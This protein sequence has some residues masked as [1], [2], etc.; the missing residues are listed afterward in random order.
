MT[1]LFLKAEFLDSIWGNMVKCVLILC[2]LRFVLHFS[3]RFRCQTFKQ[4]RVFPN[5]VFHCYKLINDLCRPCVLAE[6][7]LISPCKSVGF[8]NINIISTFQGFICWNQ[9]VLELSEMPR[10]R[11]STHRPSVRDGRRADSLLRF[12]IT[13]FCLR[14]PSIQELI[15]KFH[16]VN[17]IVLR[18]WCGWLRRESNHVKLDELAGPPANFP[19]RSCARRRAEPLLKCGSLKDRAA[20]WVPTECIQ[21]STDKPLSSALLRSC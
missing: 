8:A 9:I 21:P 3:S 1:D 15:L 12:C 6:I 17:F 16:R 7:E 10:W 18:A 14:D 11:V 20:G 13:F 4:I 2:F 19:V 5:A